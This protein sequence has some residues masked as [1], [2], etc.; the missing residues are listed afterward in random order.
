M[1][2]VSETSVETVLILAG[3][4]LGSLITSLGVDPADPRL[5]ETELLPRELM[6]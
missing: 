3:G 2:C 4:T 5:W 6:Q 1:D